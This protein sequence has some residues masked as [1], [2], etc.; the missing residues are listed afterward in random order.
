MT[1]TI[2][3]TRLIMTNFSL[4]NQRHEPKQAHTIQRVTR[5]CH[6]DMQSAESSKLNKLE[7][8]HAS[9]QRGEIHLLQARP[10]RVTVAAPAEHGSL[11][12]PQVE[13]D[14]THPRHPQEHGA[15][16]SPEALKPDRAA[17]F[18]TGRGQLLADRCHADRNLL[19]PL[20]LLRQRPHRYPPV[21]REDHAASSLPRW[22]PG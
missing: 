1:M 21:F 8:F 16:P 12:R 17:R 22:R 19:A 15:A 20:P 13:A 3:M 10:A 18:E 11:L 5:I 7:K 2:T 6:N 4:E 14:E 9:E